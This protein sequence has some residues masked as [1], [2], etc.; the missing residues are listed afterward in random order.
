MIERL[1]TSSIT[2]ASFLFTISDTSVP[3]HPI[4]QLA[5]H[6][7]ENCILDVCTTLISHSFISSLVVQ[8]STV[9]YASVDMVMTKLWHGVQE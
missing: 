5:R 8:S 4:A 1:T 6:H 9:I 3:Y 7:S 2:A